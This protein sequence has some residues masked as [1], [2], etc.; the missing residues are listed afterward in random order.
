MAEKSKDQTQDA[1]VVAPVLHSYFS[2][3]LSRTLGPNDVFLSFV[4]NR[5]IT[6]NPDTA[7]F[8][9]NVIKNVPDCGFHKE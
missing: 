4:N 7:K 6:T 8:L 2:A 5:H 3:R 9:D 1:P